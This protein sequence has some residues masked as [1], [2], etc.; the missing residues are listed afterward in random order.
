MIKVNRDIGAVLLKTGLRICINPCWFGFPRAG[1]G[2]GTGTGKIDK[3]ELK[4]LFF[5]N[6]DP[7]I[8]KLFFKLI[9]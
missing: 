2:S 5:T 4:I 8:L 3:E 1:S 7:E 9:T 6:P